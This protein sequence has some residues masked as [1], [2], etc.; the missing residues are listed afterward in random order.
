[1]KRS[2]Y[3]RVRCVVS[4]DA[5]ENK[6]NIRF[7]FDEKVFGSLEDLYFVWSRKVIEV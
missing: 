1:M 6:E 4:Y 3:Y 2:M 7:V 5:E